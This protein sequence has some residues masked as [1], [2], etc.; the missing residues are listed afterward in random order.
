MH[1]T[2]AIVDGSAGAEMIFE[3]ILR[4][5]RSPAETEKSQTQPRG[6]ETIS[7]RLR[8]RL[9]GQSQGLHR[10]PHTQTKNKTG[11]GDV[12]NSTSSAPACRHIKSEITPRPAP[13]LRRRPRARRRG[14]AR[15]SG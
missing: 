10:L 9:A 1:D 2:N 6:R 15:R 4:W 7:H 11:A 3:F 12:G 14:S 8:E 5:R 13:R